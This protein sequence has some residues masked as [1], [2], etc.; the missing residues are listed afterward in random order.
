MLY[1]TDVKRKKL[2]NSIMSHNSRII[3]FHLWSKAVRIRL[4]TF[5]MSFLLLQSYWHKKTFTS[6]T[7]GFPFPS[8]LHPSICNSNHKLNPCPFEVCWRP[9]WTTK[10]SETTISI[11]IGKISLTIVINLTISQSC[12]PTLKLWIA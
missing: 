9:K 1:N 11:T 4:P 8:V 6:G 7:N 12:I 3:K 10:L 2:I 5:S